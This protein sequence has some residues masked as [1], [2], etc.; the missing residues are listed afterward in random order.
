[1]TSE[2]IRVNDE[3]LIPTVP[4]EDDTSVEPSGDVTPTT[5]SMLKVYQGDWRH[6]ILEGNLEAAYPLTEERPRYTLH[7]SPDS[8]PEQDL[9]T[10]LVKIDQSI[11]QIEGSLDIHL[12]GYFDVYVAG[13]LFDRPNLALR[14]RSFSSLRRFFFLWD[15]TGS[16]AERQYIIT[17]EMTH[18]F[19]WNSIGRPSSVMLHEGVAVFT[20]MPGM[21]A[22]GY[23]PLEDFCTAFYRADRLPLPAAGAPFMGHIYDLDNYF[24]AGCFVKYLIETRGAEK[25]AQIYTTSDYSGV[26]GMTLIELQNEWLKHLEARKLIISFDPGT[27]VHYVDA[28]GSAYERLFTLFSGQPTHI[29]AYQALDQARIAMLAG[30]FDA[31]ESYLEKF[32]T[33]LGNR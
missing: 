12:E 31:A 5:S 7:Y 24:S 13:S 19:T 6:S 14:G 30:R 26:Y 11:A 21:E 25:F 3:L 10:I 16:P 9:E 32:N 1:L 28:V 2:L 4:L 23:I 18:T 15:G 29:K 33:V 20:G 8:L 17:H 27:L 22:A